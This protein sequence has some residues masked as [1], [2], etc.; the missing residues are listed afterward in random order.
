[1]LSIIMLSCY[2]ECHDVSVIVMSVL[3]PPEHQSML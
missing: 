2:A 3:V 1:M